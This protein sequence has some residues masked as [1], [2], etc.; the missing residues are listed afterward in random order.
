[1]LFLFYSIAVLLSIVLVLYVYSINI[2]SRPAIMIMSYLTTNMNTMFSN[3]HHDH[4]VQGKAIYA[5]SSLGLKSKFV[6]VCFHGMGGNANRF[7]EIKRQ[8]CPMDHEMYLYE[9]PGHGFRYRTSNLG[10]MENWI[11]DITSF[12]YHLKSIYAKDSQFIFFGFS[13]GGYIAATIAST[14]ATTPSPVDHVLL[15][16][17]FTHYADIG[18]FG[19]RFSK[20]TVSLLDGLKIPLH[21]NLCQWHV[22]LFA[23]DATVNK[24]SR[25]KWSSITSVTVIEDKVEYDKTTHNCILWTEPYRQ[26][27]I[28]CINQKENTQRKNHVDDH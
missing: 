2:R 1:M 28:K 14:L 19:R 10:D 9:Y 27:V 22:L 12:Y 3:L 16:C 7:D 20:S 21:D 13:W 8:I 24:E 26:W 5:A 4:I 23:S 17:P 6:W 18:R 11:N 15:V 25:S